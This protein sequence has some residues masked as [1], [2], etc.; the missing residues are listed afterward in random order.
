M[1]G[2]RR[3]HEGLK[4]EWYAELIKSK[5]SSAGCVENNSAKLCHTEKG[6][7]GVES[8]DPEGEWRGGRN[9]VIIKRRTVAFFNKLKTPSRV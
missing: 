5:L 4:Y 8:E 6:E 9:K 2:R 1:G 3:G 7:N